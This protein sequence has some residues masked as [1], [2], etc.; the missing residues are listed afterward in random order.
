MNVSR[1]V[2]GFGLLMLPVLAFGAE[3]WENPEVFAVGRLEPRATFYN[4]PDAL[5]ALTGNYKESDRYMS[6]NGK[7]KFNYAAKPADRP[8]DFYTE[9]YDTSSWADITVPGNWEMQGFGTPI[10]VNIGFGGFPVN[11]PFTS[12]TDNPV[13][14]YRRTFDLPESWKG[15][16]IFLHFGGSTSGMYVWVNGKKVGY[17]QSTKNP[18]EFDITD[19]VKPGKNSVACEVYRWTDGS[20]LEDQDFWRLSGLERDVYLYATPQQRIADFFVQAGLDSKYKNG[21]FKI[22]VDLKNYESSAAPVNLYVTLYAPDGKLVYAEGKSISIPSSGEVTVPMEA[23]LK[24]V[25]RWS[26]ETPDLYSLVI[27]LSG[28]DGKNMEATSVKVGFRTVEIKN[29]Q[30]L[31][32]GEA[33]EVHGVDLHEHHE[34]TGHAVDRATMIKDLQTMKQHNINAIRTSHYPQSPLM[35]EL[36]DEYGMYIVDEANIEIHGMGVRNNR[37]LDT[38]PH[39]AY[40]PEWRAQM[41][42]RERSLVERDKNHPSVITW[43]LGNEAGN[44]ENFKAA[45]RWIKERDK[46][47]PVQFEQANEDPHTDIV[48]PMYPSIEH[49]KR[50]AAR[51]DVTRPYI[52]CEYAHAMGNSTGNFQEYFDI[53][54]SSPHMQGGFI[55]DWVDQGF[56]TKD[57]EGRPYW[58]YG[59]DFGAR[60]LRNDDNFCI[61][62][63]VQ[64]DRTPHPGLNE[65]KKVYQDIRFTPTADNKELSIENHFNFR[66]LSNYTFPWYLLRDGEVVKKG[67]FAKV[68]AAPGKSVKVKMPAVDMKDGADY[69]FQV[70]ALTKTGDDMIPANHEVARE[71]VEL[72]AHKEF[73]PAVATAPVVK[74]TEYGKHHVPVWSI[75]G[76]GVEVVIDKQGRIRAY[77]AAGRNLINDGIEP[78]FWRAPT[79]NDW[80]NQAHIRL[81]AWR[82]AAENAGAPTVNLTQTGNEVKVVLKRELDDVGCDYETI[83]TVYG[84]G[85]LGVTET[86]I[87]K[88]GRKVPELMRF[89]TVIPMPKSYENFLWYGRGPWENYSDRKHSSFVGLY[90]GKVADQRY[91]YIRPQESGNKTDVRWAELTDNEG[92]GLRVTAQNLLNVSAL[93]VT[94]AS[95]DPGLDKHNM[96]NSDIWPDRDRV[97]FNIDLAQRGLA[98]DDSWGRAPHAP[99]LLPGG[100]YT[101]TYFLT[102]VKK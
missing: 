37:D 69:T 32:N 21:E 65:V 30:L 82:C 51:T 38:V 83:Y 63:L 58:A 25:K 91:P 43:S 56:L 99:Y 86:M 3:D 100:S 8:K 28:K 68:N 5:S 89:G 29:A 75:T 6:L 16:R 19:F 17:V 88:E 77:N 22:D 80:G 62:G 61:N 67:E 36:C 90:E 20:Y 76:D 50:Y 27:R 94:P 24:N 9:N 15:D 23:K 87:P 64:P 98:G 40:R 14:S 45:Y 46:T 18:A 49:M 7:W 101:Y 54:R 74:E 93:D 79:D 52:M 81:N 92:Y 44:G 12:H 47:R 53:I 84:D 60:D 71:E 66:D 35:Y 48:C 41:L 4:Y 96:H 57:E 85:T 70:Y 59:G 78:S 2:A 42:D 10:Y 72:Q 1:I 11:P 95:L 102:P 55:W 39:P 33:I 26:A 97:Y 34:L 73:A 31:V 13:G